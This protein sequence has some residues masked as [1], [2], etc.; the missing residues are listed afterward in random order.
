MK[1]RF[2]TTSNDQLSGWTEKKPPNT[3]QNQTGTK[4]MSQS[5]FGGLLPVWSTTT[6][7]ILVKPLRLRTMLGKSMRGTENCSGCSQ[8]WSAEWTQFF[9]TTVP[10][11][12]LHH[13]CFESWTKWSTKFCLICHVHLTS[14]Q[15][16]T[17]SSSISTT[18]CKENTST[19]S[20]RQKMLSKSSSNPKAWV[21]TQQEQTNLFL[22]GKNAFIALVPVLINKDVI[23]PSCNDVKFTVWNCNYVCTSLII[24][25]LTF[26]ETLVVFSL[27]IAPFYI[28]GAWRSTVHWGHKCVWQIQQL[29]QWQHLSLFQYHAVLITVTL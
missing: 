2:Y 15:L 4:R 12:R 14:H 7:W 13:Q 11:H 18:F 17:T 19:T 9:S 26:W 23:E 10:N 5:L 3:S 1:S 22:I 25:F 24:Q 6:L 21:F 16:T 29:K 8:H 20:R 27:M 28:W